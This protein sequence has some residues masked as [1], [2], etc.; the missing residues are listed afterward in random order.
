MDVFLQILTSE[1]RVTGSIVVLAVL[2]II[3][4]N[5][6]WVIGP[7][8]VGLVRKRFGWKRLEG[9]SPVALNGAAGYQAGC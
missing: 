5:S 6:A 7:T 4:I 9:G 1:P 2:L 8:Q 3:M